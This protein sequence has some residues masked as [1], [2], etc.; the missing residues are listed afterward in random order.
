M[1]RLPRDP[2]RFELINAFDA[3]GREEKVSL[4]EPAA[5]DGFVAKTRASVE[6]SLSNEALLHG[7]RTES[8]FEALVASLGAVEILKQE[9]SGEIYAADGPEH[10]LKVPDF[11]LVLTEGSQM[12][13]EVKNFY[14]T[15]DPKQSFSLD[16]N[17]F[18]GL[19]R[20]SKLMN[21]NLLLAVYWTKWNIWTL[22]PPEVFQKQ[23]ERRELGML[24][25]MKANHMASLGDYSV[26]TRFPLSVVM[27]AD[28]TKPRSIGADGYF[29]FTISSV[30]LWCGGRLITNST[31]RRIATYLMFYG[32]W[33][34][35]SEPK[36][37]DDQIEAVEHRWTPQRDNGQGFEI[38][39][40]LSQMF[41]TYY[42]SFTQDAGKVSRLRLNVT[43]GHW[44]RLIPKE[45]KSETLPLWR[46]VL[47]PSGKGPG[48][49]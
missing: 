13:V 12:L 14:Q 4:R 24:E 17:Y 26:G 40:S 5:T 28:K 32:T 41:S 31:E 11:R 15:S 46:F 36:I 18:E 19:I 48:P 25:A 8:M 45:Y 33:S 44:G 47:E 21:C 27:Y 30:E 49:A 6:R 29:R 2:M 10:T 37:A 7:L 34:Y 39:G 1:K 16:G 23:G 43:S 38:V 3:F 9:D 42:K 20:Y 35:D 22:V